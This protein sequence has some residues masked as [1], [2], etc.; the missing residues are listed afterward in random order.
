[1]KTMQTRVDRL[2][3][4]RGTDEAR[5]AAVQ[6]DASWVRERI[7]AFAVAMQSAG[8][9]PDMPDRQRWTAWNERFDIDTAHLA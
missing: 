2:E 9:V 7:A 8:T 3:L 6:A 1:M 4:R 5:H